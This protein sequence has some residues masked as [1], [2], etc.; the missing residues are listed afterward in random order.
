[1]QKIKCFNI[2]E[3]N[4]IERL[5]G[6]SIYNT[7]LIDTI[8]CGDPSFTMNGRSM[9]SIDKPNNYYLNDT[10]KL[11]TNEKQSYKSKTLGNRDQQQ[12]SNYFF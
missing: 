6:I 7:E 5:A 10:I 11:D 8:E 12:T 2:L 9:L 1:M 4:R 3:I